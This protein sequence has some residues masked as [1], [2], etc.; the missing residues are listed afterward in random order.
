MKG[1]YSEHNHSKKEFFGDDRGKSRSGGRGDYDHGRGQSDSSN[2]LY[3]ISNYNISTN[4]SNIQCHYC[5][6]YGY[7]QVDC[8]RKQKEEK[9]ASFVEQ[10]DMRRLSK[11]KIKYLCL[12]IS[13]QLTC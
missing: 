1:E 6:K 13:I 2:L 8:W 3:D 11:W 12:S 10:E 9:Q 7:M 4:K 5:M